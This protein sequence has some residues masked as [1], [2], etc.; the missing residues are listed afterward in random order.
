MKTIANAL[1]R[2]KTFSSRTG[3]VT[4]PEDLAGYDLLVL[5]GGEDIS[6][7][8]YG[9]TVRAARA[10]ENPS[11]RDKLEIALAREALKLKIPILGICR[12]AQL[13][14]CLLGGKLYQDVPAHGSGQ[15]KLILPQDPSRVIFSNT[16]HHQM[17]IPK[18]GTMIAHAGL[19]KGARFK[20]N[21]YVE[22]EIFEPEIVYW[23]EHKTLAVQGHPEWDHSGDKNGLYCFVREKLNELF[24]V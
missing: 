3:V 22:E 10:S 8:I 4:Y 5:H 19:H 18:N 2:D 12:G 9:E 13:M 6:P 24:E 20:E 23:G 17:M 1:F 11:T 15:H 16:C 21:G 14:C 7:S